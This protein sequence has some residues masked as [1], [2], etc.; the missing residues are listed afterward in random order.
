MLIYKSN[1]NRK[2]QSSILIRGV[3]NYISIF[4]HFCFLHPDRQNYG[5]NIY[6]IDTHSSEEFTEKKIDL[7]DRFFQIK[8]EFYENPNLFSFI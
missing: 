6:R 5:Q 2:Y 1:V 3:E 4:L 8:V 7:D